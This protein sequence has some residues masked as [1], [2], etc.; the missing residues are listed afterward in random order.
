M[1]A[2]VIAAQCPK[3]PRANTATCATA[4]FSQMRLPTQHENDLTQPSTLLYLTQM[5]WALFAQLRQSLVGEHWS[6]AGQ[7]VISQCYLV[8]SAINDHLVKAWPGT[9]AP[10]EANTDLQCKSK[11]SQLPKMS[12]MG[13]WHWRG[14][15][16]VEREGKNASWTQAL[17]PGRL[18]THAQQQNKLQQLHQM[19]TAAP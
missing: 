3:H 6:R 7:N 9:E 2:G 14:E 11:P 12:R 1:H 19:Q 8:V 18:Y 13:Y 4:G 16:R 10:Y 5:I 15:G 17:L